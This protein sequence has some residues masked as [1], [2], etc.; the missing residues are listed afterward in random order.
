MKSSASALVIR[1]KT[2]KHFMASRSNGRR[3]G[4]SAMDQ[5][6]WMFRTITI[7]YLSQNNYSY[8]LMKFWIRKRKRAYNNVIKSCLRVEIN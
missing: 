8:F 6:Y 1:D 3:Y 5:K 4:I 2:N 7:M